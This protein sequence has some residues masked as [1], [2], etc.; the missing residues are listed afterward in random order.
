M[1]VCVCVLACKTAHRVQL[2]CIGHT[3]HVTKCNSSYNA[4]MKRWHNSINF[5]LL[6]GHAVIQAELFC[7]LMVASFRFFQGTTRASEDNTHC[8][9]EIQISHELIGV[10]LIHSLPRFIFL[11]KL[12]L[13][14]HGRQWQDPEQQHGGTCMHCLKYAPVPCFRF[15][16]ILHRI[17]TI[18]LLSA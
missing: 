18:N 7:W 10:Y 14:D 8:Q 12:F 17:S 3:F 9:L 13:V 4:R 11:L 2:W 5:A 16:R 15:K 6:L 1:C